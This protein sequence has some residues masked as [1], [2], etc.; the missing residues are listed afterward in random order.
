MPNTSEYNYARPIVG[1][2]ARDFITEPGYR[3][4]TRPAP[5]ESVDVAPEV[6]ETQQSAERAKA[7]A[8]AVSKQSIAPGSIVG[9]LLVAVLL[10]FLLFTHIKV[11]QI[12]EETANLKTQASELQLERTRLQ[13]E[14]ESVFNFKELES[15]AMSELGMQKPRENQMFYVNSFASDKAVVMGGETNSI[16]LL[17]RLSD[18]F[19]S[20]VEYLR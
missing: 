13:I 3:E 17:D 10:V 20:F 2:L 4:S 15:Y 6:S 18:T 8:V 19:S 16:G 9:F 5:R 1:S 7:R 14:Y 12:S 11:A